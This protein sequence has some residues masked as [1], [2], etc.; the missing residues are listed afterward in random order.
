MATERTSNMVPSLQVKS[1]AGND[2]DVILWADPT[3]HRLLTDA[4]VTISA[5]KVDD[6]AFTPAVSSVSMIGAFFDDVSPDSVN[7]GDAGAVRMSGNRNLYVQIR[8][9]AGNERGLNINASNQLSVSSASSGTGDGRQTVTTA[10]TRVQ[11]SSQSTSRVIVQALAE[12][13]DVVV[14]GGSTVVAAAGTRRG[15]AIFATQSYVFQI[16]NLNLLYIDSVVSGEGV[17]YY[18]ET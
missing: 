18:Y 14:I 10:G 15:V 16:S 1:N 13:T 9:A 11:F 5:E 17:S 3:T 12:N 4:S 2:A 6:A 7:E 8:D